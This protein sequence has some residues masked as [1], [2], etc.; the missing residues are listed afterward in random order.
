MMNDILFLITVA[1]C[2]LIRFKNISS[3]IIDHLRRSSYR[4]QFLR[5]DRIKLFFLLRYV[6]LLRLL[7]YYN[8]L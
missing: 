1:C 3:H 4:R 6:Q 5:C 2:S 7:T 8:F